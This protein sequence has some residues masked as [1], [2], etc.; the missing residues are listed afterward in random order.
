M[1]INYMCTLFAAA[2]FIPPRMRCGS[3]TQHADKLG[4]IIHGLIYIIPVSV[5]ELQHNRPNWGDPH[6]LRQAPNGVREY[7]A[8]WDVPLTPRLRLPSS[9]TIIQ[10][11][12]YVLF[13]ISL[14]SIMHRN[15]GPI[16]YYGRN[17]KNNSKGTKPGILQSHRGDAAELRG[18]PGSP[19]N[20]NTG[21]YINTM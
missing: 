17:K 14:N 15:K 13:V 9:Q 4:F 16:F 10:T 3:A 7:V 20:S 18:P 6:G 8:L 21:R 5:V 2:I 19:S 12:V 1:P 11:Q